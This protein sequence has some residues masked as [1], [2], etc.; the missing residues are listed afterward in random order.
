MTADPTAAA[1]LV[2]LLATM[3]FAASSS[4]AYAIRRH[5]TVDTWRTQYRGI[6]RWRRVRYHCT[7]CGVTT[8]WFYLRGLSR[9]GV[10]VDAWSGVWR[11][12]ACHCP[13]PAQ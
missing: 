1:V 4:L 2:G 9:V 5:R 11:D 7:V 3:A 8:V 12:L 13:E 6:S 10:T